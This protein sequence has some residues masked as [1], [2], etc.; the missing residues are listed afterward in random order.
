MHFCHTVLAESSKMPETNAK[1][2]VHQHAKG[3]LADICTLHRK[4]QD[5][6]EYADR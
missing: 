3:V 4:L 6:A 5:T 1:K 2:K